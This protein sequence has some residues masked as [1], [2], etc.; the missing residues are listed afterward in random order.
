M[1]DDWLLD[2]L[3]LWARQAAAL[4]RYLL[5]EQSKSNA[6]PVLVGAG[7]G[8]WLALLIASARPELTSGIVGLAADPDFTE[9]LLMANLTEEQKK[10]IMEQGS[11]DIRWGN[12]WYPISRALIEDGRDNL[13]LG[14]PIETGCPV[15]ILQGQRDDAVPWRHALRLV[16]CLA[17]DD[18]VLTLIK[19]GDQ[20]VVRQHAEG[21]IILGQAEAQ[22]AAVQAVVVE[23]IQVLLTAVLEEQVVLE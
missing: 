7:V 3:A 10:Q 12:R 5:G 16:D 20:P 6:P 8:G 2:T 14:G 19:D 21:R 18:V 17:L 13:L 15:T 11:Q 22:V 23:T 9:D 1:W 4:I